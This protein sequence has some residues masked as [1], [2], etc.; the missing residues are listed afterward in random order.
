[1]KFFDTISAEDLSLNNT[2]KRIIEYILEKSPSFSNVKITDIAND[3]YLSSNT[4]IRLCKK[5]GYSGFS[6][7]KYDVMNSNKPSSDIKLDSSHISLHNSVIKTLSLNKPEDIARAANEIHSANRVV[8][9][10]LGLSQYPALSFYK[11]LQYFNKMC[12]APKDRDENILFANNLKEGD[13][14]FIISSSGST[15][16]IK[17]IAG[18]IKTK[19]IST[20]SLT[21]FSQNFLSQMNDL[22]LFAYLKQYHLNDNDLTSRLG[23]NIVLDLIFEDF[24]KLY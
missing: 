6:E 10:S 2:E 22:H 14:A 5:L 17:K 19:N 8:I 16:I 7:L 20:I 11:K 15:D 24:S 3:L 12:L 4:I 23:F 21:G 1:M 18:I 13:L 9:F